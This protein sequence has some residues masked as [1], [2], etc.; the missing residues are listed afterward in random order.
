[1]TITLTDDLEKLINDRVSSG[2]YKS[3]DEV[4]MA[5]LRLLA[6]QEQGIE[7]LS[8]EILIGREDI[9]QGRFTSCASDSELED[10]SVRIVTQ[11]RDAS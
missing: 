7:A 8:R 10:F 9:R 3:P 1:V 4:I 6:A 11:A 2:A 5:G